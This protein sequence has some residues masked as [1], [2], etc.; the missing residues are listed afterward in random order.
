L[1]NFVENVAGNAGG[2]PNGTVGVGTAVWVGEGTEAILVCWMDA[3]AVCTATVIWALTST[4][5]AAGWQA[6]MIMIANTSIE[7]RERVCR[8]MG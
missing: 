5:G 2:G 4:E 8:D 3:S 7:R 1:R 6:T